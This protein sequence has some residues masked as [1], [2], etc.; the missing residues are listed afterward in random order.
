MIRN[1]LSFIRDLLSAD[2]CTVPGNF[3]GKFLQQKND[4]CAQDSCKSIT[5]EKFWSSMLASYPSNAVRFLFPF[6]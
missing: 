4:F 1:N 5:S 6:A 3:Q 2:I